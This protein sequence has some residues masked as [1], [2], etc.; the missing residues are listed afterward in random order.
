MKYYL[1]FCFCGFLFLSCNAISSQY[2][3]QY[4]VIKRNIIYKTEFNNTFNKNKSDRDILNK[5][6]R[7][8]LHENR[9]STN[10]SNENKSNKSS[11]KNNVKKSRHNL[12]FTFNFNPLNTGLF[13]VSGFYKKNKIFNFEKEKDV[14]TSDVI[15]ITL[16]SVFF[17]S[18]LIY[19]YKIASILDIIVDIKF[20]SLYFV[21]ELL[22][23]NIGLELYYSKTRHWSCSFTFGCAKFLD[24]NFCNA[25]F[26][27]NLLYNVIFSIY[28]AKYTN[29]NFYIEFAPII[30]RI[31]NLTR[32][33]LW[34]KFDR[35]LLNLISF[36]IGFR[37]I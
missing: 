28:L 27:N 34:K 15:F 31:A 9:L 33:G 37:I 2:A 4:K 19:K 11:F 23:F 6:N 14:D 29:K 30:F 8:I 7:P 20:L 32:E 10:V 1:K 17:K 12:F 3:S 5:K 36:S 26:K 21:K 35:I 24:D 13:F 18:S 16:A 22:S 25:E